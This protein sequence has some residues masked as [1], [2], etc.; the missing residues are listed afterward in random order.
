MGQMKR[1]D[2]DP[3]RD[4]HPNC[5]SVWS[6]G[7]GVRGGQVIRKSNELSLQVDENPVQIHDLQATML[8]CLGLDHKRLMRRH[9]GRD[10]RLTDV[11]GKVIKPMILA[12]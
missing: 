6:A 3:G 10:F 2:D 12:G 8:H 7:G 9:I 1:I 4:H 5:F 11:V